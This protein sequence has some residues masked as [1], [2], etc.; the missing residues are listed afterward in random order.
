MAWW[1][2]DNFKDKFENLKTRARI[3][4]SI[5][6]WF[7]GQGF[8]DVQ[9]P[10]LQVMPSP[11]THIHAFES[12][13][14][15]RAL[16]HVQTLG[17][18]TSPEIAMKKLL[19]AGT[20]DI[21]QICPVFRNSEEGRLHSPEFTML[22]WYRVKADYTAMMDDCEALIKSLGIAKFRHKDRLCDVSGPWRRLSVAKA[23]EDYAQ[24]SSRT[25]F[26]IFSDDPK[27]LKQVQG[28]DVNE[29]KNA[30]Q[31]IGVRVTET[32][33]WDDVFHAVMA[34][35]IEPH[36]GQGTPTFLY[37]YPVQLGALARRKADNINVAERFE[38]YICGVELAN[39]FSELTDAA[40]Q[41]ARLTEDLKRKE[42]LYGVKAAIDEDFL[43]AL[44]YGM[45]D[46]AGCALG[47]DRLVMLATGA[48]TI[49][50]VL[51]CGKP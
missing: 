9:T 2:P 4:K 25:C 41:R 21:Y 14:L 8:T 47:L 31:S 36:L 27:T 46:S 16:R 12:Q 39:A 40:E 17:L 22:E 24:L 35:K 28:D 1:H 15:D 26:G 38:L 43:N 18:H 32:D 3:I 42:Q 29:F 33:S 51:W 13:K 5:R 20:G 23:F 19:V 7:D 50:D 37:D 30:A 48:D 34:E 6:A 10:V 49:D 45:P 11:D 44:E